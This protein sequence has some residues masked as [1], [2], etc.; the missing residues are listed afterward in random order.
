[1]IAFGPIPSRRL[2]RSLGVNHIPLKVC[3]YACV[4][5]QVGPTLQMRAERQAFHSP[6]EIVDAVMRKVAECRAKGEA[7]DYISF[8]PDGEPTLDVNLGA[9]I[10]ALAPLGIPLAVIT[11][12]S[13]LWMPEVRAELAAADLVSV[14][15]D[16]TRPGAWHRLD[17]PHG[18]IDLAQVLDGIRAFAREYRGT[19]ITDTMLVWGLND[20][21]DSVACVADFLA[22]IQP[23]R[24][25]LGVPTR[26]PVEN[27]MRPP[28]EATLVRAYQIMITRLPGVELLSMH[29][30]GTFTQTG[31]PVEGLLSILAVHPM[32]EEAVQAYLRDAD[33][34]TSLLEPLIRDGRVD[35][36]AYQD[37]TFYVLRIARQPRPKIE[38]DR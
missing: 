18:S 22:E 36:V 19:L 12:A 8:V 4:Y 17:R 29:E 7:I 1:M 37:T 27:D 13:L 28:D 31:D 3:S 34:G 25:Y 35:R 10:R 20:D 26:P 9:H 23:A 16:T 6:A 32:R 21:A 2:G 24:A 30:E 33:A 15:V 5:C 38:S 14:K 11:N